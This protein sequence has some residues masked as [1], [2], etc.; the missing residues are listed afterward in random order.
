MD[1]D[2]LTPSDN[3][4]T[5]R[6]RISGVTLKQLSQK[7]DIAG[8]IRLSVHLGNLLLTGTTLLWV[9]SMPAW[10]LLTLL[11]GYLLA[12]LFCAQHETAHRT[13]FA[14][15]RMNDGIGHVAGFLLFLPHHAFRAFHWEHHRHTQ[16][17]ER[18]PELFSP[19]PRTR[20]GIFW[21]WLGGPNWIGRLRGFKQHAL[22][23]RV[24]APWIPAHQHQL[25][26]TESRVYLSGYIVLLL[27]SLV[28]QS[29]VLFWVWLLPLVCGYWFLRPYLLTEHT[30]CPHSGSQSNRTRTTFTNRVIK[31]YAW[32][33]PY[34]TEHHTYPT[35][36]FHALP[37]LHQQMK[38]QLCNTEPGY[39]VA[40]RQILMFLQKVD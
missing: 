7:S 2:W 22:R 13:A 30:G 28:L 23:A 12:F 33:M 20:L 26:I 1:Q 17:P 19:L 21:L 16:D 34:H 38:A 18:D 5:A 3:K 29:A 40:W 10:V 6:L 11:H 4:D 24:T 8:G 15:R 36:P 31:L 9:E 37:K 39:L 32:N 25:I 14:N 35:V 27:I